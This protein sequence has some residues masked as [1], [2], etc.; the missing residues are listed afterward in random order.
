[1]KLNEIPLINLN[2]SKGYFIELFVYFNK[3]IGKIAKIL[4]RE[5]NIKLNRNNKFLLIKLILW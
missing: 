3:W 1:M 2:C 5:L 4:N